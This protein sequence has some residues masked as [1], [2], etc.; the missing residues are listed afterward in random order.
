MKARNVL[1]SNH[2]LKSVKSS[3]LH[4]YIWSENLNPTESEAKNAEIEKLL[5]VNPVPFYCFCLRGRTQSCQECVK[6]SYFEWL[7]FLLQI[8]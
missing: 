2:W 3:D 8:Y 4:I 5:D 7:K 6:I 1:E